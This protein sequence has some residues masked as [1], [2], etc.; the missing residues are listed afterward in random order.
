MTE[1]DKAYAAGILDGE[2]SVFWGGG[3]LEVRVA[4]SKPE[5]VTWLAEKFGGKVREYQH[6]DGYGEMFSWHLYCGSCQDF[7][8]L[9][10]PYVLL[11]SQQ[12]DLGIAISSTYGSRGGDQRAKISEDSWNRTLMFRLKL[13]EILSELNPKRKKPQVTE[14]VEEE[15]LSGND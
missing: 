5:V 4:M 1:T 2:G 14:V 7:L 15:V 11:K 3:K 13:A 6:H 10:K 12:V 8:E 9:V